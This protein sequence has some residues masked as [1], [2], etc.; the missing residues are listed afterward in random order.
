MKKFALPLFFV[1]SMIGIV[2]FYFHLQAQEQVQLMIQQATPFM[3]IKYND[4]DL[5]FNG[6][7]ILQD[8]MVYNLKGRPILQA[9]ELIVQDF[10]QL[11][12]YP[13]VVK[14]DL[15]E[16]MLTMLPSKKPGRF[17]LYELGYRQINADVHLA[18]RYTDF[19]NT[20]NMQ[21]GVFLDEVADAQAE[22]EIA[23]FEL[24]QW[25]YYSHDSNSLL[26][27]LAQLNVQNYTLIDKLMS[28]LAKRSNQTVEELYQSIDSQ[29]KFQQSQAIKEGR[30]WRKELAEKWSL[31]IKK[32]DKIIFR[33]RIENGLSLRRMR[34]ANL[35]TLPELMSLSIEVP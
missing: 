20:L 25:R 12:G 10:Q 1:F 11:N 34:S 28:Y 17:G 9:K 2:K 33:S 26:L 5:E 29:I 21:L 15:N 24:D 16:V 35:R 3:Q 13:I 27:T 14:L 31:F 32:P 23:N 8:L 7:I 6:D 22:L 4:L 19:S 30:Q 18:Y